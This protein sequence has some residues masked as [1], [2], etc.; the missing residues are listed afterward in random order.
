MKEFW[1]GVVTGAVIVLLLVLLVTAFRFFWERDRK[2]FEAMEAQHEIELLQEDIGGR[3]ADE[4]LED[5]AIR[6]AA[7]D[8]AADFRRKRDEAVQRIRG[9]LS[10]E[11]R[12][13]D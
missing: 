6:G 8:A 1:R 13:A 11:A 7:D 4:F 2:I 5:A 10:S 12:L 3:S 9:G